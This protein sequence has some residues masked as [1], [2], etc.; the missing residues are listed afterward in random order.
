MKKLVA[1]APLLSAIAALSSAIAAVFSAISASTNASN[2]SLAIRPALHPSGWTLTQVGEDRGEIRFKELENRGHGPAI[3]VL[4][5]LE[6]DYAANEEKP[7]GIVFGGL[8]P[9]RVERI[10]AGERVEVNFFG[11]FPLTATNACK[12][13]SLRVNIR[14]TDMHGNRWQTGYAL[15]AHKTTRA[16][17]GLIKE[18]APN[19][20]YVGIVNDGPFEPRRPIRVWGSIG[21][22]ALMVLSA[23]GFYYRRRKMQRRAEALDDG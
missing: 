12:S 13:R 11:T 18:V 21:F 6:V 8:D 17:C 22:G 14:S 2:A 4:A 16:N 9:S 10:N 1:V 7:T 5:S 19:L 23:T 20:G 3:F 15:V